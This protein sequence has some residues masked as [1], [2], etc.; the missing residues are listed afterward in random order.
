ME[1][2]SIRATLNVTELSATAFIKS[3]CPTS[4]TTNDCLSGISSVLTSP[5]S[6]EVIK[7]CQY[8]ILPDQ[9]SRNSANVISMESDW[10]TMSIFF[11]GRRSIST[12]ANSENSSTGTNCSA[13]TKLSSSADFVSVYASHGCAVFC[14]HVP[15]VETHMP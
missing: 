7:R 2:P 6:V 3:S 15:M 12:P 1:G 9:T 4:S 8:C 5:I 10:V 11:F 14:I 13:L